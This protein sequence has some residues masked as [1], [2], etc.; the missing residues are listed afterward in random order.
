M[1]NC[2]SCGFARLRLADPGLPDSW[3]LVCTVDPCRFEPRE[4]PPKPGRKRRK[5]TR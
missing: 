3:R 1:S 5:V 4:R 2:S